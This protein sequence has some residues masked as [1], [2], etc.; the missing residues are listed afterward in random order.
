LRAA[1]VAQLGQREFGL[2][3]LGGRQQGRGRHAELSEEEPPPSDH[4]RT[5]PQAGPSVL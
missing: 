3:P 4:H 5:R 1:P 2:R